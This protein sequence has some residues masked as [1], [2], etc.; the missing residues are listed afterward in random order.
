MGKYKEVEGDLIELAKEGKFDVI[1]HGCNCFCTMGAGLA[2]QMAKAFSCDSYALESYQLKGDFNKLGQIGC[3]SYFIK[4]GE[5]VVAYSGTKVSRKLLAEGYTLHYAVNCYTQYG[6]GPRD[7]GEQALDYEALT[8]C[9]RKIN[10]TFEGK[11][12]GLPQIGCHLAGGDW[13]IVKKIIQDELKDCNVTIVIYK[14]KEDVSKNKTSE[15]TKS[16]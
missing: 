3:G 7:N 9:L 10:H 12:V 6:M 15:A 13:E 16:N 4:K 1:A 14:P 2:P 8:L 11:H 5:E